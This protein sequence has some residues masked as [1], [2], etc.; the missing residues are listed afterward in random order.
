MH[1][2]MSSQFVSADKMLS[3]FPNNVW[4]LF[5]SV[6]TY[7][8]LCGPYRK[9]KLQLSAHMRLKHKQ[10]ERINWFTEYSVSAKADY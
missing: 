8:R 3:L 7:H 2:D 10:Q 1:I 6:R 9:L 5:C 4:I